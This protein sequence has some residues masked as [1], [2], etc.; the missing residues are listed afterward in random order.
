MSHDATLSRCSEMCPLAT[1]WIDVHA[2]NP[3]T[4]PRECQRENE[5]KRAHLEDGRR[6]RHERLDDVQVDG[7]ALGLTSDVVAKPAAETVSLDADRAGRRSHVI[8]AAR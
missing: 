6:G 3:E 4:S 8:D 5:R 2:G 7:E 1:G